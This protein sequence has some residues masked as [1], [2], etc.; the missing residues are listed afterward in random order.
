MKY[1][2]NGSHHAFYCV[3]T[4]LVYYSYSING[5]C[6]FKTILGTY[7]VYVKYA[8]IVFRVPCQRVPNGILLLLR[9]S[10]LSDRPSVKGQYL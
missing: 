9:L 1:R 5:T 3:P 2:V 7:L 4:Y 8:L 10:C 6:Y